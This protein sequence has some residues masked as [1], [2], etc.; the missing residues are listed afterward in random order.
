MRGQRSECSQVFVK[1]GVQHIPLYTARPQDISK[2]AES[3]ERLMKSGLTSW[4]PWVATW[5]M[6]P[7]GVMLRRPFLL[8]HVPFV[9]DILVTVRPPCIGST[10]ST[11]SQCTVG[12][13]NN[14]RLS[15]PIKAQIPLGSRP[16]PGVSGVR[17]QCKSGPGCESTPR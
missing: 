10:Q 5:P 2:F 1:A 16:H 9:A 11:F 12:D 14:K 3:S 8:R 6:C 17:T 15:G 4:Q 7:G 13:I